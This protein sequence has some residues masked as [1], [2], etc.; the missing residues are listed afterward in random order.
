MK[1]KGLK[2][3]NSNFYDYIMIRNKKEELTVELKNSLN[4]PT[5]KTNKNFYDSIKELSEKEKTTEIIRYYLR[6]NS[7]NKI[8]K[9]EL[10]HYPGK[11][12]IIEGSRNLYLQIEEEQIDINVLNEILEKYNMDRIKYL[13]TNRHHNIQINSSPYSGFNYGYYKNNDNYDEYTF[14]NLHMKD[15]KLLDIEKDFLFFFINYMLTNIN[16]KVYIRSVSFDQR[17]IN[18]YERRFE[19]Y[20]GIY[21]EC[22]KFNI[23]LDRNTHN[24]IVPIIY[25]HNEKIKE[26]KKLELKLL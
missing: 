17:F 6:N 4:I 13:L 20:A 26:S 22:E 11:F 2:H 9:G 12:M 18:Y 8:Y 5:I 21:I 7:I 1:I 3:L 25:K 19:D 15:N 23:R 10:S 16:E 14:I 24:L